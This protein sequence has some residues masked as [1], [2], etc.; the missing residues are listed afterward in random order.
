VFPCSTG[1]TR[2][3]PASSRTRSSAF[4]I[5]IIIEQ[6]QKL[7]G[8][9][10]VS[11]TYVEELID[12]L[13]KI[14]DTSLTTL[15]VGATSL[16]AL[17][18][19]RR[20]LPKWPRALI[21]V[22]LS[23]V[24]VNALDLTEHDVAVTGHVPTGLFSV[25]LPGVGWSQLAALVAGGFS[26]VFVGYSETLSSARAMALK[27]RYEIDPNQALIAQGAAC[28]AA[29]FVGGFATDGSLSKSSVADSAGQRSQMASLINALFVLLTMLFLAS[30]F[31]NLPAAALGAVV[32]DAMV[33]VVD[34]GPI[35]RDFR[36]NRAYWVF[37][38][39]AMLGILFFGIIQGILIGVVLSLLLLIARSS[40]PSIRRLGRDPTLDAFVD[41]AR[42]EGLE[43]VSG[44]LVLRL[45]GP[46]FFAD[47]NRF[48]D[49]VN[50][51]VR[52]AREPV[53]A[54]VVDADAISLTDTDG[55]DVVTQ[56]AGELRSQGNLP[57]LGTPRARGPRP[58]DAGGSDRR[59]RPG[60]R[61]R[62]R[63]PGRRVL[64]GLDSRAPLAARPHI[65]QASAF[66]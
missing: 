16:V 66:L 5:G 33:G 44:V 48:R 63:P 64:R 29:G 53:R 30:L 62:H 58:V 34:F 11:G 14:P 37:S 20:F 65:R 22:A 40:Q 13:E 23:I 57:G 27:H 42:H 19:M 52:S 47:A 15:A 38:M 36:V 1:C 6:S 50:D 12:T 28:G 54:V 35:M 59:R 31:E 56:I 26:V 55:A 41:L 51:M 4:S 7:L 45:D 32:I 61:V 3:S 2:R 49:G 17:L 43:T 25:Q 39:G 18:L 8:I 10:T 60:S 24:A 46:L 21:V 9:S